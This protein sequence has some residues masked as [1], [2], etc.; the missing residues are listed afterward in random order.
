MERNFYGVF[1]V[2]TISAGE[3]PADA[4][5]LNHGITAHGFQFIDPE[6][7]TIPTSYYGRGSGIGLAITEYPQ[8]FPQDSRPAGLRVGVIGL[9]TGT[10]AVYGRSAD[11]YRFYEINPGI[12]DLALGKNGYFTYLKDTKATY[13][14]VPGDARLSLEHELERGQPQ[15]FDI[16]AVDAFSSDSIPVHLLTSE[17]FAVYLR[18]LKPEGVLAIHISNRYLDLAPLV[19]SLANKYQLYDALIASSHT[20]D[21]SYAAVWVLLTRNVNF[22]RLPDIQTLQ[23]T[24][25]PDGKTVRAWTD[26]YSNLLQFVR[27]DVFFKTR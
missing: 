25:Q 18:H 21:G 27:M 2:R 8:S 11:Y 1:R 19:K 24:S 15:N 26:D 10:L 13:D 23:D 4:H 7:R 20:D 12:I 14:I 9:G 3:P 5:S 17:A 22:Y 16:L 6:K